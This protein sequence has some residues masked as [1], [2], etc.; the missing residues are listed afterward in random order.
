MYK[1]ELE[2]FQGP[3]PLLLQLIEKEELDITEVSLANIAEQYL[4]YIERAQDLPTGDLADFL[5]VAAKLLL[6]KSKLLLPTLQ[7]DDEETEDL[8]KQLKIYRIYYDA[9]KHIHKMIGKKKFS[10]FRESSRVRTL[11]PIFSPP[12]SITTKDLR[13]YFREVLDRIEPVVKLPQEMIK[14]TVSIQE[15]ISEIKNAISTEARLNFKTLLTQSKNK[16]EVIV[17]F[18]ALLELVK[19]RSV[20][21][22]QESVFEEIYIEQNNI[23]EL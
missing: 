23:E 16:T 6:I 22:I 2:Q 12:E 7:F 4:A 8:E 3:L 21:V 15:K 9:S 13:N 10:Y 20:H 14:K 5:V 18:L 17:T 11:E 1:I 19:Q